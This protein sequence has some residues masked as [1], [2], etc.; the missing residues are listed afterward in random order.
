MAEIAVKDLIV[1]LSEYATVSK[2]ADLYEAVITLE[3]AWEEFNRSPFKHRYVLVLDHDGDVVGRISQW[4]ILRALE[5][6]YNKLGQRI[7][8]SRFGFRPEILESP[9]REFGLWQSPLDDLCRKAVGIKVKD[10]MYAPSADQYVDEKDSL[11][12]AIHRLVV[13][14]HR[15]LLVKRGGKVIGV[16][17]LAD[18][19]MDVWRRMRECR[20]EGR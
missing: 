18:V 11:Q 16:L 15:T 14:R 10:I 2:D 3:K 5:P 8:L 12:Q 19:F 6:G 7:G 20:L 17:R 1:D 13:G 4:D 9:L